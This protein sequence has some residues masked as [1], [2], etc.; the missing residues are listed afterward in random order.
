[1][2]GLVAALHRDFQASLAAA[3]ADRARMLLRLAAGLTAVNVIQPGSFLAALN[4]LATAALAAIQPG[5]PQKAA[6]CGGSSGP[7]SKHEGTLSTLDLVHSE[8][9]VQSCFCGC[10]L[11]KY[12]NESA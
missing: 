5:G 10:D 3:D 12:F 1:M 9:Q 11:C 2:A 6:V 4:S 7:S 8:H